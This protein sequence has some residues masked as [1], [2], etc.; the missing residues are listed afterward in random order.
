MSIRLSI[1]QLHTVLPLF[2]WLFLQAEIVVCVIVLHIFLGC[3]F[4]K[5]NM[6]QKQSQSCQKGGRGWGRGLVSNQK[7]AEEVPSFFCFHCVLSS[8][9]CS[10]VVHDPPGSWNM[11]Q[12][13]KQ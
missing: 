4:L 9:V 3:P 12:C 5:L 1:A 6:L 8:C 13:V 11:K 2:L 7:D 10:I